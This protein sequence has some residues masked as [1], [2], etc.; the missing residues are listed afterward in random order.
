MVDPSDVQ[1]LAEHLSAHLDQL[2]ASD[3]QACEDARLRSAMSRSYY[4]VFL[5]IKQRVWEYDRTFDFPKHKVH[6][7]VAWAFRAIA[8]RRAGEMAKLLTK[9]NDADYTLAGQYDAIKAEDATD[10]ALRCLE[11]VKAWPDEDVAMFISAL[12]AS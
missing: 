8:P 2:E 3:W 9:R 10:S 6:A 11:A 1:L 12:Q 4:S 5:Q 7:K